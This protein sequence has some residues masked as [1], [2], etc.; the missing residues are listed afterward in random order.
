MT[1][2]AIVQARMSSRR[3]PGKVLNN[4]LG[5]PMLALQIE[6]LGRARTADKLAVATSNQADDDAIAALCRRTV[7][8]CFRGA[9]DD[10]LDRFYRCA[11]THK[12]DH[13][14][15]LTGDCPLADPDI[16]DRV[17]RFHLKGGYDYTSNVAP[18]TWPDG[19]DVEVMK[20]SCLA[21]AHA[22]AQLS[23]ERE[24]VTPFVR[25]RPERYWLGNVEREPDLS[26]HRLTV[27]EPEDFEKIRL[28]YE[29]LYPGN[30]AFTFD[31]VMTLLDEDAD[32]AALN[33]HIGR[34]ENMR[35]GLAKGKTRG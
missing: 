5:R 34:N 21:E 24:H 19:L 32:L 28:I 18:P 7:V 16:V 25:N 9:L 11:L 17:V 15:R 23:S 30:P 6:R 1:I 27:D 10:V 35:A 29:R 26:G 3:L 2:I 20:F 22:E 13:V 33:A 12:A 14:V 8:A 31:D 4:I